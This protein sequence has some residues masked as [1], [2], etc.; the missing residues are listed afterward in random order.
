MEF[1]SQRIH[2]EVTINMT[3]GINN[4]LYLL[5]SSHKNLRLLSIA[6]YNFNSHNT[7]ITNTLQ[8]DKKAN[9]RVKKVAET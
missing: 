7:Y 3:T 8:L 9:E 1:R 5:G 6:Y 4:T 2:K